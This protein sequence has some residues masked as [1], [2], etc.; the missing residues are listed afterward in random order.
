MSSNTKNEPTRVWVSWNIS[1]FGMD[2][3]E[4][5]TEDYVVVEGDW[6]YPTPIQIEKVVH[7]VATA[8]RRQLSRQDAFEVQDEE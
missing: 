8:I 3:D 7:R 4:Q 1:L 5:G 6:D 2:E